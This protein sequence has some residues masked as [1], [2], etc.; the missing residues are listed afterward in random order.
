MTFNPDNLPRRATLRMQ[1]WALLVGICLTF[2]IG[3]AVEILS[4]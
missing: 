4:R 2:W 1:G 3:L